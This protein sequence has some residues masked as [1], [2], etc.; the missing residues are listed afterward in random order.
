M[1]YRLCY[2][3]RW[4]NRLYCLSELYCLNELVSLFLRPKKLS[5]DSYFV[6]CLMSMCIG[7]FWCIRRW[8]HLCLYMWFMRSDMLCNTCIQ[9]ILK[10]S[11]SE[12]CRCNRRLQLMDRAWPTAHI[13]HPSSESETLPW[14]SLEKLTKC[15]STDRPTIRKSDYDPISMSV[16]QEP[17]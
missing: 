13:A 10:I 5:F 11:I 1:I 15:Q 3:V 14:N 17:I 6:Y 12:I 8:Y 4:S 16:N 7:E 9:S 2:L